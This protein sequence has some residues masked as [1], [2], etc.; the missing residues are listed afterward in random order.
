MR[1]GRDPIDERKVAAAV[2]A[3]VLTFG[4]VADEFVKALSPQ[5]RN[6]K[7]RAQWS[8]T[9]KAYAAPLR[10]LPVDHIE[11]ADVLAVLPRGACL[12]VTA[13]H[14]QVDVGDR[15]LPPHPD[16]AGLVSFVMIEK[17]P[18]QRKK[19]AQATGTAI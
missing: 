2:P 17:L 12:V 9:L 19:A 5:W 10:G 18:R 14:G 15:V 4:E 16:V 3:R 8:M 7:H 13:D 6:E 11:T 1:S